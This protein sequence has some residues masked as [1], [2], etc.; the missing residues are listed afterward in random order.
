MPYGIAKEFGGDTPENDARM[1]RQV[2]AI[3]RSGQGKVSAIKIA[4]AQMHKKKHPTAAMAKAMRH[5]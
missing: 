3:Q 4:K 5:G 2:A 1:E